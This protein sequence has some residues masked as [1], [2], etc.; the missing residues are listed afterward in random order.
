MAHNPFGAP[1]EAEDEDDFFVED[2]DKADS[3]FRV[4]EAEF[5]AR[6]I[7]AVKEL[8]KSSGAPMAVVTFVL[9]GRRHEQGKMFDAPAGDDSAGK[10]FKGWFSV[11]AAWKL[12]ELLRG[13][14][15]DPAEY[16]ETLPNGKTR[17]KVPLK[18]MPNRMCVLAMVDSEYEGRT[19]SKIDEVIPHP[20][21]WEA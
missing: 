9:T 12:N 14:G 19:S 6:A 18:E 3:K 1:N 21:G 16:T 13:L 7:D 4:P 5:E 2:L 11:K 10:E 15:F 20:A 8:S 17:T